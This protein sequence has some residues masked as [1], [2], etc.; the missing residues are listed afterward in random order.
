[1]KWGYHHL[2]KHPYVGHALFGMPVFRL[3]F[4]PTPRKNAKKPNILY[5]PRRDSM[6]KNGRDRSFQN[7]V[8]EKTTTKKNLSKN[9]PVVI[10]QHWSKK[11]LKWSFFHVFFQMPGC[12]TTNRDILLPF[13]TFSRL[14]IGKN[15]CIPAFKSLMITFHKILVD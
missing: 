12:L 11:A 9:K 13:L 10:C 5:L 7:Y 6:T 14:N 15:R 2:R 1:M 3:H 4:K 8:G